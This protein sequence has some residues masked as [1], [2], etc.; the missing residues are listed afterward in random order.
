MSLKI[1]SVS[2]ELVQLGLTKPYTIS[3]KT[4]DS[5]DH[6]FVQVQ[7]ENGMTGYGSSNV[8]RSVVGQDNQ[9]TIRELSEENL[10]CLI[11]QDLLGFH[12]VIDNVFSSFRTVGARAAL[13][14]ALH[15]LFT[16]YLQIP[17]IDLYGRKHQ[18]LPTSVTI[19]IMDEDETLREARDFMDVG[20]KVLKVKL[21]SSFGEDVARLQKL[22]SDLPSSMKIRIDAN[23]GW[24]VEETLAFESVAIDLDIELVE[25]PMAVA[26]DSHMRSFPQ[27]L[28][29]IIAADESLVGP[30]EALQLAQDPAACGIYNI[31][32]MKCAGITPARQIAQIAQ[33]SNIDLMWGCNDESVISIAAALHLALACPN[34]KYLDLDGSFDLASDLMK[35]GF[36]LQDGLL[37]VGDGYGLGVY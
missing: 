25:Q 5:V 17:L 12:G 34:T 10:S 37:S 11:G 31:K 9:D 33:L 7:A 19:G 28:K 2:A 30:K 4:I 13:D 27:N 8:S 22:C 24:S 32:L 18:S 16:K 35:G 36:I 6:V 20:F 29:N 1:K 21:G 23:C 3:Y 26:N 15:D 14:I